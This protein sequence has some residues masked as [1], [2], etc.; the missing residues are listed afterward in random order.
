[1]VVI[2]NVFWID[3]NVDNKEN[4]G[5]LKELKNY[6]YLKINCFKDVKEAVN[7]IKTIE[8]EETT[9][10]VSG[11][12]YIK[13]IE[14]FKENLKDIYIIPKIIIFTKNK[15]KF[16]ESNIEY[17][18]LLNHPFYNFGGI[19]TEFKEVK[20]IL[21]N[22]TNKKLLNREDEGQLTF[23]YINC[24]EKL[25]LPI[26]YKHLIELTPKD[27]IDNFMNY[28]YGK[29][30]KDCKSIKE[31]LEP[32]K[33]ISDIPIEILSKYYAR[34]YTAESKKINFYSEINKDLR[35]NK[36]ENYL[37]YIKALYEGVKLKSLPLSSNN[38]LYRGTSLLN[39][40]IEKI[41]NYKNMKIKN[42]PSAIVFSRAFLSF[43]KDKNISENFLN[44]SKINQNMSKVLFIL[45]KDDNIDYS[46]GTHADI[47]KIS[48]FPNEKE[49]LFFPFS[50]FEIED[51]KEIIFNNETRYEI[52][53]LYL[54]KYIKELENDNSLINNDNII[55]DCEYK[56]QLIKSGLIQQTE[57]SNK[58]NLK[59][60]KNIKIK[61]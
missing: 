35:E 58:N 32:I 13:F 26:L 49:V 60:I 14:I 4:S 48:F 46:L 34:I 56:E 1:M 55:P 61:I 42:L 30:S 51:I 38:I 33:L 2:S 54:G 5:Y 29:Y 19:K 50:A 10:I 59:N 15:E 11:R 52:K 28:I 24:K 45:E 22:K 7:K 18:N 8:F 25:A 37:P 36:K 12:L 17:N 23:E 3:S 21:L 9:I 47:E 44:Q 57:I 6:K 20:K 39:G 53:L 40:E 16:I 43:S 31:L 41:K 27:K